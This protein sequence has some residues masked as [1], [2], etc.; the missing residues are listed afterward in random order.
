MAPY[1]SDPERGCRISH[2]ELNKMTDTSSSLPLYQHY[3]FNE[4]VDRCAGISFYYVWRCQYGFFSTHPLAAES[5]DCHLFG[6]DGSG[7]SEI[8]LTSVKVF[9]V[10]TA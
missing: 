4:I 7:P 3:S 8:L 1:S 10:R 5:Q 9:L 2:R 6:E